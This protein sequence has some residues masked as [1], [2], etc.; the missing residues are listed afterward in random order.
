[1]SLE[2][3]FAVIAGAVLLKQIPT[4]KELFGCALMFIAIVIV[5]ISE[6]PKNKTTETE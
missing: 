6:S 2:S 4:V 5:Q 1:M 3:V